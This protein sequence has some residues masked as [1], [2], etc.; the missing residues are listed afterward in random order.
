MAVRTPGDPSEGQ[1]EVRVEFV[2]R[3]RLYAAI[4]DEI[5]DKEAI[6]TLQLFSR[7]RGRQEFK[8]KTRIGLNTAASDLDSNQ[9]DSGLYRFHEA[10]L[11]N[12]L[13]LVHRLPASL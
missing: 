9:I 11:S 2:R 1:K 3:G 7:R 10:V 12:F 8:V 6:V 4:S 13:P 5:R